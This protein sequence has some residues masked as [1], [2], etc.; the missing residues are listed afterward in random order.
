MAE[1]EANPTSVT[2][3]E[4]GDL[5]LLVGEETRIL[6]SSKALTLASKVF[7]AML[8]GS[9]FKEGR[10]LAESTAKK[11][12]YELPLP[13][14]DAQAITLLSQVLCHR[15]RKISVTNVTIEL[16][17][18]LA[19]VAD[20]YACAEAV[21]F[22]SRAWLEQYDRDEGDH[23][24][25]RIS[26]LLDNAEVF[27]NASRRVLMKSEGVTTQAIADPESKLPDRLFDQLEKKRLAANNKISCLITEELDAMQHGTADLGME[28]GRVLTS[29]TKQMRNRVKWPLDIHRRSLDGTFAIL[30]EVASSN[31]IYAD[32][33][34]PKN[35]SCKACCATFDE[36]TKAIATKAFDLI[37]GLCLDCVQA[38]DGQGKECRVRHE[39]SGILQDG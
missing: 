29:F 21:G 28:H 32:Y 31:P 35:T 1:P 23:K 33:G 36:Q 11:E 9:A 20:K 26:Y 38:P 14:D 16:L 3:D 10:E 22:A 19:T 25:L 12:P 24:L 18:K 15:A 17:E 7:K 8:L 39:S 5:V 4:D 27:K 2:V 30:R 34:Y 37:E 6:V 13:D